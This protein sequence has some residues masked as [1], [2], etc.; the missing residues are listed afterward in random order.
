MC[1]LCFIGIWHEISP[2]YVA[3][4]LYHGLGIVA[5]M[6]W[7]KFKRKAKLPAPK[8]PQLQFAANSLKI[9][10]TANY[11]FFGYIITNQETLMDAA[12]VMSM[13]LIPWAF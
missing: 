4:G 13:I 9:L 5:C 1:S 8:T 12:R 6:Q 10:L 7:G 11:F 3:W 2:R